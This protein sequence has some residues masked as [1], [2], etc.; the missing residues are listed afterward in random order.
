L[1]GQS[2]IASAHDGLFVSGMLGEHSASL[3]KLKQHQARI[4]GLKVL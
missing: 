3:K 1:T 4:G 2:T